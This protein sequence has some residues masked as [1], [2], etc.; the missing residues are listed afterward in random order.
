MADFVVLS[1][2]D[3]DHPLWT[4]KQHVAVSLAAAG[5]RVLYIDSLGLRPPRVG[6]ADRGRILRRLG[7]ALRLPRQVREGI[8]VWS[9]LVLPGGTAGLALTFNRKTLVL[10]LRLVQKWLGFHNPILW[11]YNPLTLRYLALK[12]FSGSV[13]HCVDRIQAQPGM[14]TEKINASECD[15]CR[16]VDVVFTTSPD[17]QID[18]GKV[19]PRTYFF[20]NVADIQHFGRALKG[21]LTCPPSLTNLARPRLV[22]IGAIDAYKLHLP[23]LEILVARNP[24]WTYIFVGPV[25]ET[26]PE[27]D[28]STLRAFPNVHFFGQKSYGELPSWLAH[29][30]VAL[31]PLRHNDYTRHM[32]PM[33]F[34]EY[35]ASGI[36]VVATAIPALRLYGSAALICDPKVDSFESALA[37]SLAGGG[38]PLQERLALASLHT[39]EART[40]SMLSVLVELGILPDV[41]SSD[42]SLKGARV[43]KCTNRHYWP[44]WFL[45]PAALVFADAMDRVRNC[46]AF[47]MLRVLKQ[48]LAARSSRAASARALIPCF[49][50]AGDYVAALEAMEYL[51]L[52]TGN[53]DHLRRLLFRRSARPKVPQEQIALFEM[54]ASSSHLP[55][56]YRC[57]SR[58]VVAYRAID[59]KDLKRMRESVVALE[60]FVDYLENDSETRICKRKNRL[61]LAKLLVSCYATLS[62]LHLALGNRKEYAAIGRRTSVFMDTFEL[63]AIDRDTSFRITRNLMRCLAIDVLEAWRLGDRNLYFQARGRLTLVFEHCYQSCH[64]S[65]SAQEDH[66]GFAEALLQVVDSLQDAIGK[67]PNDPLR[68]HQL[69]FLMIKNKG[70]AQ[71]DEDSV[72][73]LFSDYLRSSKAEVGL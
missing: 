36:P 73:F 12:I 63:L 39:Y 11:T 31:L 70:Q 3:W 28:I 53:T 37:Q 35:L 59:T 45:S 19:N 60:P 26:D 67:A 47:E 54:L 56:S 30:D 27:T 10:G 41:A 4:N 49:I 7:R 72:L 34:F 24:Q 65:S 16:A 15:L 20:G 5:H 13:Y 48:S 62:R 52:N 66:R 50:A 25:G 23:M 43:R 32:F 8:W 14:P 44:E 40:A 57:Y 1:T 42:F 22:F 69:L 61:N 2:A 18:F 46:E 71:D 64:D 33:K 17:L 51:W 58:V 6:A 9:P 38:P 29:C 68:I 21:T 55:L